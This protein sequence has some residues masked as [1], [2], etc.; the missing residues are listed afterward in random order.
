MNAPVLHVLIGPN[1][2]GKSTL[3]GAVLQPQ[4]QLPFV[5]ADEIAAA[6]W[7]GDEVTHAYE[8]S[9]LAAQIRFDA[10]AR[11]ESFI[12]ETVFSHPSKV[13]LIRLAER[14]GYLVQLHVVMVPIELALHRVNY[15]VAD[16][17]HFVPPEKIRARYARLWPLVIEA[18]SSS[19]RT[20]FYDN[21]TAR[22]PFA[23]VA[24]LER[25]RHVGEPAWPRWTPAELLALPSPT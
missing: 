9:R 14:S 3:A 11:Q 13:D 10:V 17:G 6:R 22:N 21:S 1:G 25:D 20:T 18:T 5:N 2:A 7:P 4:T 8:A 12:T 24:R 23:V 15:R 19:D 16:G